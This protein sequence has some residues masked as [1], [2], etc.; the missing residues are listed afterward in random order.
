MASKVVTSHAQAQTMSAF[1]RYG[2]SD[3]QLIWL[4]RNMLLQRTIDNRGFQLNRQ[5]KIPFAAGSEGHEALQAG[6]ALAF[7]RGKDILAGYYRDLGLFIGIGVTPEEALRSQFACAS[8]LNGGRQFPHHFSKKSIGLVSMSSVIAAH[9]THAVGIAYAL[10]YRGEEGRA[11][12]CS[13][14]DGATSQG[15]WHE[16][17]N[18][19]SVHHLPIVFLCENNGLAISVPL[20]KQMAIDNVSER[21]A[22]YGIPGTTFDGLDP[23]VSYDTVKRALDRARRGDGPSLIEGKVHRY[24]GHTTDDDDR[25]YRTRE[26]VAELRKRDPVPTY[27]AFLVK[28]GILGQAQIEALRK[29]ILREIDEATDRAEAEP[30]PAPSELYTNVWEGEARPWW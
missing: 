18:F 20:R 27:E 12:L 25:T 10:K 29:E 8:D 4:L 6:A 3:D 22:A 19:A 5:G 24:L 23:L 28:H 16:A 21:A 11:V 9:C 30:L 26:E 2:L 17:L 14:G 7:Q 15:E 1:E 13:F